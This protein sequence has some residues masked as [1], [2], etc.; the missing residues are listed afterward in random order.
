MVMSLGLSGQRCILAVS[1][2]CLT[3]LT[4]QTY[5]Q[6]FDLLDDVESLIRE[7]HARE[8]L[9]RSRP[10]YKWHY[11]IDANAGRNFIFAGCNRLSCGAFYRSPPIRVTLLSMTGRPLML[12]VVREDCLSAVETWRSQNELQNV[13]QLP[14]S[15]ADVQSMTKALVGRANKAARRNCGSK[16][17]AT[18]MKVV[19]PL[20][21]LQQRFHFQKRRAIR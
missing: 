13:Q 17:D 20:P 14:V 16:V 5:A 21:Q 15:M 7:R 1:A 8:R 12:D 18:D 4:A 3:G 19:R 2:L 6:T 9:Y 11:E 10:A